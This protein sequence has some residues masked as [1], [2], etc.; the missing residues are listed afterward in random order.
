MTATFSRGE[1]QLLC[2]A[3]LLCGGLPPECVVSCDE[4]T[5]SLD[6]ACDRAIH[7]TVLRLPNTVIF[8][9]H[10]LEHLAQFDMVVLLENGRVVEAGPPLALL[11][12]GRGRL[13]G[14][15]RSWQEGCS[16]DAEQV[17]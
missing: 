15:V 14:L 1:Q 13:A 11:S 8:I 17:E 4:C 2:L 3:R 16:Q 9:C 7:D 6:A 5:A 10:R 12:D